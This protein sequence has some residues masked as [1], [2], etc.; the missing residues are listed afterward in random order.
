[1]SAVPAPTDEASSAVASAAIDAV[2]GGRK[3]SGLLTP[4][5]H[6]DARW[7]VMSWFR[8]RPAELKRTLTPREA[9]RRCRRTA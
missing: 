8:T 6:L 9:L 1:V 4:Y 7:L 5:E 2:F 3:L